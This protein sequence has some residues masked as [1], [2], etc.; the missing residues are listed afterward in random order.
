MNDSSQKK[1]FLIGPPNSGKTS[2]FN[3]L[4]GFKHKVINYPGSTVLAGKG[5]LLKKYDYTATIIDTPGIYSLSAQSEDERITRQTLL[6]EKENC[7]VILVLDSSKLE[8]Q[9]PIFF[10]L[11]SEGFPLIVALSMS[12]IS[13]KNFPLDIAVF[14]QKLKSPVV[15]LNSL[16]GEGVFQLI[17]KIKKLKSK[18][19]TL[20]KQTSW[21]EKEF[22]KVSHHCQKIIKESLLKDNISTDNLF[23]SNKWDRFFLNPKTGFIF[24]ALIMFSLFSSIFWLATPFMTAV[25]QSFSFLIDQ[26]NRFLSFA[27]ILAELISGGILSS[28]GSVMIFV[29]QIF[30]LFIGISLLEDTGYLARAVALMD[31]PF[32]KMGLSGRSFTPFLSAYACAIPAILLARNISSVKEKFLV[33]FATP[34][35]TC[36]ARLP[37]YALLLSFLFYGQSAWKPGLALSFIYILSFILGMIAVILL[38]KFLK[39]KEKESFLLDLPIYRRPSVK[40]ILNNAFN[41]TKHYIISAGPTIFLVALGIWSLSYFPLA[42]ELS[43]EQRIQQSYASQLGQI[44][45]PFFQKMGLDWRVGLAL[46]TAFAAREV[47]VSSLVLIFTVIKTS[48]ETLS[49]SLLETMQTAVHSNGTPLFTTASVTALIVFFMFSLQCLSTTAIVYKESQSLKLA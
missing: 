15:L 19:I 7:L 46:I 11:K 27:P 20:E 34:F 29:P 3:W 47:F 23:Y 21:S 48:N 12:D 33:Y 17:A 5:N 25:D 44:F 22:N 13:Q 49:N 37:V 4:T 14:S 32:S 40:K 24:F 10:Q 42:P 30:I 6:N 26:S 41:R 18:K 16:T 1:I 8:A 43:P 31:G 35:M 45:E 39:E 2:L 36:S 28:F 9:L 38:N